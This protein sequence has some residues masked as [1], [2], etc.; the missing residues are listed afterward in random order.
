MASV[1]ESEVVQLQIARSHC[2][3]ILSEGYESLA[4]SKGEGPSVIASLGSDNSDSGK[5]IL[6]GVTDAGVGSSGSANPSSDSFDMFADDDDE[7]TTVKPAVPAGVDLPNIKGSN[8]EGEQT[9]YCQAIFW[10]IKIEWL[11]RGT[12][13]SPAG[14]TS[15]SDYVYDDSSGYLSFTILL[16]Q[17]N[18]AC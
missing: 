17:R 13:F 8:S 2:L 5:D 12:F 11:S 16:L 9:C 10:W 1:R 14:G 6:L 15:Q 4:Q 7:D 3:F 18:L